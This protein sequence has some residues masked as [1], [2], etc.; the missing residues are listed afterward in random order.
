MDVIEFTRKDGK[1][2]WATEAVYLKMVADGE[3]KPVEKKSKAAK[4]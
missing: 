2:V 1:K 3:A 4:K